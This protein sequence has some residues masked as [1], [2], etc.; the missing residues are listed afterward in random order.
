ME[1]RKNALMLRLKPAFLL[2]LN[3]TAKKRNV[4]RQQIINELISKE[5]KRV[6]ANK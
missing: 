4:R 3:D 6:E 1:K 5:M 2:W